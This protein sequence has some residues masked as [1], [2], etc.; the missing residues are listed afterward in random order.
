MME[1]R[2]NVRPRRMQ[3][4]VEDAHVAK[5]YPDE[6]GATPVFVGVYVP[7]KVPFHNRGTC[8]NAMCAL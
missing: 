7:S 6:F 2:S 8:R 5:M 1:K 4:S 3:M